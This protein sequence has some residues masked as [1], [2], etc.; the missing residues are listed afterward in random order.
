[1]IEFYNNNQVSAVHHAYRVTNK[2]E[3]LVW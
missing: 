3:C 1:M 2:G